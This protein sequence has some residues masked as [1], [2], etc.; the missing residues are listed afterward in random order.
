MFDVEGDRLPGLTEAEA[1]LLHHYLK[2]L[3]SLARINP[4]R[5]DRTLDALHAAQA[6]AA[7]AGA[8][9]DALALLYERGQTELDPATLARALAALGAPGRVARLS[10]TR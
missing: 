4:A 2:A 8:I 5:A 6:L 1:D 3:D 9:R 7:H 10:V